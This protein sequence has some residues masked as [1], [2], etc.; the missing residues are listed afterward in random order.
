M[1]DDNNAT[2]EL[3]RDDLK[4]ALALSEKEANRKPACLLVLGGDLNGTIF[5]LKAGESFF[6]RSSDNTCVLE[7]EGVSR[8]HFK[9][10]ANENNRARIEDLK[11]S[12]GTFLNNSKITGP[13]NLSQGDVIKVGN[14]TL[15]F[16]PKGD[17]E[18]LA[19]D[20]LSFEA[21]TD[22]LTG[23]FNKSCFNRAVETEVRRSKATG[24][25]L[26]L[27][28]FDLDN[29]KKLN[30][31]SGHDAGDFV[32]KEM[33]DLIRK[34]GIR[35]GD[36]FFRCGGEEFAVL[37]P[38]TNVKKGLEIAERLRKLVEGHKF[39]YDSMRIPVTVSVGVADCR[40]DVTSGTDLF[41]RADSAAYRSKEGGR[42][43]VNSFKE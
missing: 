9:V 10:T 16:I 17:P 7:F 35:E 22:G 6:G 30:D 18:R 25:P 4:K 24:Q 5:D 2:I 8:R 40:R 33:A 34:K 19:Y 14:V 11:S 13:A 29:F 37:L 27:I 1:A 31:K 38:K 43:R 3:N 42:N 28:V 15:K 41:K 39:I 20:K 23:C 36:V 12:N 26:T 21:S 32:L